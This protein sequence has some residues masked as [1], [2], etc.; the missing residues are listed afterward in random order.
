MCSTDWVLISPNTFETKDGRVLTMLNFVE[1]TSDVFGKHSVLHCGGRD[2]ARRFPTKNTA[3][4]WAARIGR[5]E[6]RSLRIA[7]HECS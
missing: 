5:P 1:R 3:K 6:L 4:N 2:E 7:T